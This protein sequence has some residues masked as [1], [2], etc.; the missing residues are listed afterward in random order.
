MPFSTSSPDHQEEYWTR[1]FNDFLKPII[2]EAG[3]FRAERSTAVR[4]D[5]L[6]QIISDLVSSPVVV[7]D[8]TDHNPNVFWELGVRQSFRHGTITIAEFGTRLPFDLSNKGTL[9]YHPK[10]HVRNAKFVRELKEALSD[11][12]ARP[13]FPDS[14]IMDAVAG[15]GSLYQTIRREENYRR[16]EALESEFRNNEYLINRVFKIV[17][18]NTS[19]KPG[20]RKFPTSKPRVACIELLTTNRYLDADEAFYHDCEEYQN[21]MLQMEGQLM[22]WETHPK[23]TEKW[24]SQEEQSFRTLMSVFKDSLSQRKREYSA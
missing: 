2:E 1:H 8:L 12:A 10:D 14:P 21:S 11:C 3:R 9:F 5:L 20:G 19:A 4:G 24:L 15:R 23:T 17:E 6:K 22:A 13:D 16:L 18:Q 7:A